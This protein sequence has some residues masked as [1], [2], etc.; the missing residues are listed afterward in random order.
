MATVIERAADFVDENLPLNIQLGITALL[1]P[2]M[3]MDKV[4]F[5][6]DV[7]I[8]ELREAFCG[9]AAKVIVYDLTTSDR[10]RSY[11]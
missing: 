5:M 7:D 2:G 4:A 6:L 8:D 1:L 3:G 11:Y 9:F 10:L